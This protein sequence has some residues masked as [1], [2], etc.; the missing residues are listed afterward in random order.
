MALLE[1]R[2][3]SGRRELNEALAQR[4]HAQEQFESVVGTSM[5]MTAYERLRRAR[6]RLTMVDRELRA[7]EER[8]PVHS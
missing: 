3:E 5:E 7:A 6:R 2:L 4:A 1:D 8:E